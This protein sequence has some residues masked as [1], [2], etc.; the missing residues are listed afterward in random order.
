MGDA[1]SLALGVKLSPNSSTFFSATLAR[2]IFG[3]VFMITCKGVIK[4]RMARVKPVRSVAVMLI[5]PA[6][7]KSSRPMT[8]KTNSCP[9]LA[10][11]V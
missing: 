9:Q 11:T 6:K 2:L 10:A 5:Q 7:T 4:Y 8:T 1:A 3:S